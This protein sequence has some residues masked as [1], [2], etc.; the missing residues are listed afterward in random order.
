MGPPERSNMC[1]LCKGAAG[2]V[3]SNPAHL[4]AVIVKKA[5]HFAAQGGVANNALNVCDGS[6][7]RCAGSRI[8]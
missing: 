2:A 4:T 5:F 6:S 8:S 7:G 3:Q 1:S